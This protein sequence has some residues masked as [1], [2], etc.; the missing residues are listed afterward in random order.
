[1]GVTIFPTVND[2]GGGKV[3]S[4]ENVASMIRALTRQTDCVVD[5]LTVD[6]VAGELA[7]TV[8]P[9]VAIISGYVVQVSGTT[10][11]LPAR[12]TRYLYLVLTRDGL[13]HVTGAQVIVDESDTVP[14]DGVGLAQARTT[15]A[16]VIIPMVDLRALG[17]AV[18]R[19]GDRMYGALTLSPRADQP[20]AAI[21]RF[22]RPGEALYE[23][24][25]T[26]EGHL[27]L[28]QVIPAGPFGPRL[29]LTGTDL[30][31]DGR[32]LWHDNSAIVGP[33]DS[34]DPANVVLSSPA[35]TVTN[36]LSWVLLKQF[37]VARPG[38]YRVS[39]EVLT[40]SSYEVGLKVG[41]TE[42]AVAETVW[43]RK[44]FITDF[45]PIGGLV[46]V[47][48][49]STRVDTGCYVRNVELL[50]VLEEG[51]KVLVG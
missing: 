43:T 49:R 20:G 26:G 32:A 34:Y 36:S 19:S 24:S 44:D 28:K 18:H 51:Y 29:Q 2:V 41:S 21:L 3:L 6:R 5:G 39:L 35:Q 25:M 7:V 15:D 23:W 46:E 14:A 40:S 1:V 45:L 42:I 10:V 13:G 31:L 33:G 8:A 38:R 12:S 11:T 48:G 16:F 30:L 9:G 17:W 4:E 50:C 22:S 37:R 27:A 47:F